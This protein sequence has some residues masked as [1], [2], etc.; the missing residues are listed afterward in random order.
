MHIF[1]QHLL[2]ECKKIHNISIV[3]T[4]YCWKALTTTIITKYKNTKEIISFK[5]NLCYLI[6]QKHA[7][8]KQIATTTTATI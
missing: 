5:W 7:L 8:K 1:K 6:L 2:A 4:I 3:A